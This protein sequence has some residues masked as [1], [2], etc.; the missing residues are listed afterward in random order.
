MS[1]INNPDPSNQQDY[2]LSDIGTAMSL[3]TRL[4]LRE[5][6]VDGERMATSAWAYPIVGL[7]VGCLAGLLLQIFILLGF[8]A[9]VSA[10][11]SL[12]FLIFLTGGL[13]EDGIAD[14]ADGLGGGRSKEDALKIMKDSTLG[15]Y[16]VVILIIFLIARWSTISELAPVAPLLTMILVGVVSRLPMVLVMS[17]MDHARVDGL[18]K[19]VGRPNTRQAVAALVLVSVLC[20]IILGWWALLLLPVVLASSLPLIFFASRKIGG[21]TGDILG[22]TQQC[23]EMTALALLTMIWI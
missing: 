6:W 17:G 13:H 23:A 14:C 5:N 3:L 9:G 10:A 15:T 19:H 20:L 12:G 22:G 11:F 16:G 21:Q 7:V 8:S 2:K 18:S 4:P 1:D